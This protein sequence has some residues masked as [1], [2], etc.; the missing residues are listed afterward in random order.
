MIYELVLLFEKFIFSILSNFKIKWNK[1]F[2]LSN[3][4]ITILKLNDSKYMYIDYIY[5]YF[6]ILL[7][8]NFNVTN[9]NNE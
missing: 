1:L 2:F 3:I 9:F 4:M 7:L 8:F 5:W 6:I